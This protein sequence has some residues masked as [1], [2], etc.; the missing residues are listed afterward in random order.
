MYS[1][2][3]NLMLLAL[4]KSICYMLVNVTFVFP[5]SLVLWTSI[6][7][8]WLQG[9]KAC[10]VAGAKA[11]VEELELNQP[12]ESRVRR[13]L[14][15]DSVVLSCFLADSVLTYPFSSFRF[16]SSSYQ[17]PQPLLSPAAVWL[18]VVFNRLWS[19]SSSEVFSSCRYS[20]EVKSLVLFLCS[21]FLLYLLRC[22]QE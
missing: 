16:W 15:K 6:I 5:F 18:L 3:F 21:C 8:C 13:L 10:G 11:A 9:E 1:V 20:F 2:Q 14:Q 22:L 19:Q 12:V 17:H 7:N 4:N